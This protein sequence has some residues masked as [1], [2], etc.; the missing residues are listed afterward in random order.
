MAQWETVGRKQYG[1]K[2]GLTAMEIVEQEQVSAVI[3]NKARQQ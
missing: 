1:P 3:M 2:G